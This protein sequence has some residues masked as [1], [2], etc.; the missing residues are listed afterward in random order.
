MSLIAAPIDVEL[1]E[2]PNEGVVSAR[3]RGILW[4]QVDPLVLNRL[5][6]RQIVEV[7]PAFASIA[8]EE[9]NAVFKGQTVGA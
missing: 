8:T 5:E 3:G 4:I 1:V 7:C 6:L 9:E 2:V